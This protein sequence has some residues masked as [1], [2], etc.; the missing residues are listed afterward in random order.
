MTP[1]MSALWLLPLSLS[2]VGSAWA[3]EVT[4]AVNANLAWLPNPPGVYYVYEKPT[5]QAVAD[6]VARLFDN[7]NL[8]G[9]AAVDKHLVADAMNRDVPRLRSADTDFY[10]LGPDSLGF[11][12]SQDLTRHLQPVDALGTASEKRLPNTIPAMEMARG[13]LSQLELLPGDASEVE[14]KKVHVVKSATVSGNSSLVQ[15]AD[16]LV[17]VFFGRRLSGLPVVGAS[18]MVVRLGEDGELVS[19]IRNWP[20]L[21]PVAVDVEAAVL[22]KSQWKAAAV[23]TVKGREAADVHPHASIESVAIVMYDDG[24]GHVEPALRAN[25]KRFDTKGNALGRT[26]MVPIMREPKGRY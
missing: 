9:L 5:K 25:G 15:A 13:Y 10:A 14:A 16:G 8:H 24:K 1:K 17:V 4:V 22:D 21:V 18:R 7:L 2:L 19:I 6:S 26:W 20:D 3:A 12:Y 23:R 11:V